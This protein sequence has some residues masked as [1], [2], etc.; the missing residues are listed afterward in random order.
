MRMLLKKGCKVDPSDDLG[1]TALHMAA[2]SGCPPAVSALLEAGASV[3]ARNNEEATPL[4]CACIQEHIEVVRLLVEQ[5]RSDLSAQLTDGSHPIFLAAKKGQDD[6]ARYL[7]HKKAPL[8]LPDKDGITPL[9][10][11]TLYNHVDCV[12]LLLKAGADTEK[13]SNENS[14][15]PLI[16]AVS[17]DNLEIVRMLLDKGAKVDAVDGVTFN[18]KMQN[19]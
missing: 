8:N 10:T 13:K 5:G 19:S 6:L 14:Y 18:N 3:T 17:G 12:R 7:I 11:A 15:T 1:Q 4:I 16:L 2:I 9:I